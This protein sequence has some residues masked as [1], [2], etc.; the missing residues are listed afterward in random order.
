MSDTL[1][2]DLLEA[3]IHF[4]QRRSAWNPRM[5]PYIW[6]ARNK[7]HI[8]DIRETIKG[9][10][11]AKR[12]ITKTVQSGKDVCFIGTKRQARD[13]VQTRS[14]DVNMPWVV[15]RWLG[16]TLTNFRTIRERLRRLKELEGLIE[17]GEINSYSK[18]M[19]SQLMREKRKITRNLEGIRHMNK[20]PGALVIIDTNREMN[21]L[22]EARALHI[23]TIALIDTDGDPNVVDLPIPGN[24]DSM[25]S[26][27]VIMRELT[28]AVTEGVNQR[29]G[30]NQ[31]EASAE[32]T[33][34]DQTAQNQ[35]PSSSRSRFRGIASASA[36]A[37]ATAENAGEETA[38]PAEAPAPEGESA[39]AS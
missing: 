36:S 1:V 27:D 6:G 39:P 37:D 4:G 28:A 35:R 18:K 3:G 32:E 7:I 38:P 8:I 15:E 22:R 11:L 17:T 5:K 34:G 26:I 29:P 10:L 25:R 16:G 13:A 30:E 12:F 31:K 21:A 19:T 14:T 2:Q 9:L 23:P 24:D 33:A 20:L